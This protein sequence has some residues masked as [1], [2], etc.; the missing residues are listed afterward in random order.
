M[1]APDDLRLH[2]PTPSFRAALA[3]TLGA[4]CGTVVRHLNRLGMRGSD[5][6]ECPMVAELRPRR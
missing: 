6:F 4:A 3:A 5:P 1:R 2:P